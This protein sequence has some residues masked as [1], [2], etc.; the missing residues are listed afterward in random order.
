MNVL[1]FFLLKNLPSERG[2][3]RPREPIGTSR[4]TWASA[5]LWFTGSRT[6]GAQA[7]RGFLTLMLGSG[8]SLAAGLDSSIAF[9]AANKFYEQGKF[10][11]AAAAYEK[12]IPSAPRS[13][14]LLFNLG[15][16]WF[17]AGQTGLAIA[18]YR[19]AEAI[20]P[21][22][23]SVQFNL[24]FARKKVT[25]SDT[26]PGSIWSR[27]LVALTLNE[28]ALLASVALWLWFGLLAIREVRPVLRNAL[29]GYTATAGIA[30]LLLAICI[31]AAA[32]LHFNTVSAVVAVPEA[33][34]RSGPLDEAKV[35]HQLRDGIELTVLDQKDLLLGGQ[36]QA[37]LQVSDAA[38]RTGWLKKDQVV[39]LRSS[40][41]K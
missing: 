24:Q 27:S 21:R 19:Q 4:R 23:P 10:A 6:Q 37:W 22:D 30:T 11:E 2:S 13:E 15:N 32:Q 31:T 17:K 9:D 16:A 41:G 26:A 40:L 28:W 25:G 8:L 38:S 33:I 18:A 35:L 39:L 14:T 36:T 12:L 5:L 1:R 7:V 20:A 34:V 3:P 29:S